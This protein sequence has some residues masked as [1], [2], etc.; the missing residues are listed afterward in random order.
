MS[1]SAFIVIIYGKERT[2]FH[3]NVEIPEIRRRA[4]RISG[5]SG[6]WWSSRDSRPTVA[7]VIINGTYD[8]LLYSKLLCTF[9]MF[10][11]QKRGIGPGTSHTLWMNVAFFFSVFLYVICSHEAQQ[12]A[13]RTDTHTHT[14]CV[15]FF[16][17]MIELSSHTHYKSFD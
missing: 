2:L 6:R 17:L 8:H 5:V 14:K 11:Q 7:I 10:R 9:C 13:K 15:F 12:R 3:V 1:H 16:I 4:L